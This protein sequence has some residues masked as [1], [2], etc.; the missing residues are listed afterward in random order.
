M[1]SCDDGYPTCRKAEATGKW[2]KAECESAAKRP[3]AAAACSASFLPSSEGF[4]YANNP[5][6]SVHI[7]EVAPINGRLHL[8]RAG[9]SASLPIEEY[10]NYQ[11]IGPIQLPPRDHFSQSKSLA[12]CDMVFLQNT[13]HTDA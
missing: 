8:L 12:Y 5:E 13:K 1:K 7:V 2:C 3:L 6:G 10:R 9:R 11:F 4:Y